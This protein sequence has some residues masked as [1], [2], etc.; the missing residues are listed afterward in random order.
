MPRVEPPP[1]GTRL[2]WMDPIT[3]LLLTIA[4]VSAAFLWA[5]NQNRSR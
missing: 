3:A 5:G 1:A 2:R 4:A